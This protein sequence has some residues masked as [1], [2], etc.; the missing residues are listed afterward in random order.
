MDISGGPAA[1]GGILMCVALAAWALGRWQG[2]AL[3]AVDRAAAATGEAAARLALA[4]GLPHAPA[5]PSCHCAACANAD[6]RGDEL[7]SASALGAMHEEISAYR[8][9]E[10][11]LSD[12][13]SDALN[14]IAIP[15]ATRGEKR[16]AS[17]DGSVDGNN[18][19][20]PQSDWC[21]CPTACRH[22][23]LVAMA[24]RGDYRPV[25]AAAAALTRV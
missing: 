25:A 4:V 5:R 23:T 19:P 20:M 2:A 14:Q 15:S 3:A 17:A 7:A 18:A 21:D 8:R 24:E 9:A 16:A 13:S 11:I 6:Y 22:T 1:L 12:L 10:H